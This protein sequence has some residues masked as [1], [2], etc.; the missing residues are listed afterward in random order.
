MPG[1][2]RRGQLDEA[3]SHYREAL[4]LSPDLAQAHNNLGLALARTG[5]VDGAVREMRE[6]VRLAPDRQDFRFNLTVLLGR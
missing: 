6:A 4:R 1:L 5:D 2:A 3:M